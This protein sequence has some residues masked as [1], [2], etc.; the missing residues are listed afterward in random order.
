VTTALMSRL[1]GRGLRPLDPLR[2]IKLKLAVLVAASCCLTALILKKGLDAGFPAGYTLPFAV[3]VPLAVSLL[4]AHGMTSPL[5]Q[6]TAVA[7]AMARGDYGRSIRASSRDEVGELARAFTQMASE[8][9]ESDRRRR[10]FVA[11]VSHELRTPISALHALLEN[12][13]DGITPA[14]P[15]AMLTALDQT[16]RLD[17]LISQLLALSRLDATA[18]ALD[19]AVF[20]AASF[21]STAVAQAHIAHPAVQFVIE[22]D[23]E[24]RV[25]G[26]RDRLY[27]VVA[28]LLDNA[29][30][31]GPA[32]GTVTITA[33]RV[34]ISGG[35][36]LE[37]SDEGPG[38]PP[39]ERR[40]VFERFYRGSSLST[41]GGTG[42]GLAIARWAIE[43][44]GGDIGVADSPRGCCIRVVIPPATLML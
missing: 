21:L 16:T 37:I 33:R 25:Y 43:L 38:I 8:L 28:N 12:V 32:D 34:T 9:A 3:V 41:D 7:R 18:D 27:Q 36:V 14:Q 4:L 26:D 39:D 24:L 13:I 10:E 17:R 2:S 29:A 42:L 1:C 11:N 40:Q 22:A 35:A 44:H 20:D 6:M 19:R 31:H 5:R 23:D 15:A 30:R